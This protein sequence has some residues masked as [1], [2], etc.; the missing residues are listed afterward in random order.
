MTTRKAFCSACDHDVEIAVLDPP[1]HDGQATL[2]DGDIVCLDFGERCT[3][4]MCPMFGLP[5]I[6]MGVRLARSGLR[7]GNFETVRARCDACEQVVQL[8]VLSPTRG[9]CPSCHAT[10]RLVVLE[11]DDASAVALSVQEQ[12]D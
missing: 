10:T 5:R 1:L 6:V 12:R 11:L 4:A 8:D 3:G 7:D 9:F 2:P